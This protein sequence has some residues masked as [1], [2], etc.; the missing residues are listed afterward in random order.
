[1]RRELAARPDG[2]DSAHLSARKLGRLFGR[3]R[4]TRQANRA[5][6]A[7]HYALGTAPGALYALARRR[8]P[9]LRRDSGLS[10]G[11]TLF[12]VNDEIAAPAFGVARGAPT[13]PGRHC[14]QSVGDGAEHDVGHEAAG[15]CLRQRPSAEMSRS[16]MTAWSRSRHCP[17]SAADGALRGALRQHP[18]GGLRSGPSVLDM[19][20]DAEG[21]DGATAD[22]GRPPCRF[23]S[24]ARPDARRDEVST[25]DQGQAVTAA[26]ELPGSAAPRGQ[27]CGRGGRS[28]R[29]LC[30]STRTAAGG[31]H[32]G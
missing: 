15:V 18:T 13:T 20:L 17:G 11:L 3:D 24:K 2:L 25:L 31:C 8:Y 16:R 30:A 1:M 23:R 12:V 32:C 14:D 4:G 21:E 9:L 5:G 7:V 19:V 28:S 29:R 22:G 6:L 27:R 10:Y 26:G